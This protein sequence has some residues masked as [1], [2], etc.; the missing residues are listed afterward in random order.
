MQEVGTA[1]KTLDASKKIAVETGETPEAV[2]HRI[3]R[4]EKEIGQGGQLLFK[5]KS[6]NMSRG[7]DLFKWVKQYI[8]V[9]PQ[10]IL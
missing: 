4:G 6:G 1:T 8:P 9:F 5:I 2:R 3:R 10:P 7:Q